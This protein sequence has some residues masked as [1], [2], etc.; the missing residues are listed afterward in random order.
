[1]LLRQILANVHDLQKDMDLLLESRESHFEDMEE[2]LSDLQEL[3]GE[4]LETIE[5]ILESIEKNSYAVREQ[6]DRIVGVA[7]AA[8]SAGYGNFGFHRV[9]VH[10]I[11]SNIRRVET[12]CL[13]ALKGGKPQSGEALG[14]STAVCIQKNSCNG[15]LCSQLEMRNNS[16]IQRT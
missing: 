10:K 7:N 4:M 2:F 9:S 6:T 1:M 14:H 15:I 3:E 8:T 5:G 12:E 13:T 11:V 16:S